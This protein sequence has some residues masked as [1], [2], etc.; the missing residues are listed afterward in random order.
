MTGS[1]TLAGDEFTEPVAVVRCTG[2]VTSATA[3]GGQLLFPT[4]VTLP[5]P[6][7]PSIAAD[8]G[9]D[10]LTVSIV[11]GRHQDALPPSTIAVRR[12]PSA[13]P[14]SLDANRTAGTTLFRGRLDGLPTSP[15]WGTTTALVFGGTCANVTDI[16]R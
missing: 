1:I 4:G 16:P 15:R 13:T 3:T 11:A 5:A 9:S 12:T 6:P 14:A 8:G 7:R 2:D 10:T